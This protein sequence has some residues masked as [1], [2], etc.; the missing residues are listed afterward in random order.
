MAFSTKQT[1]KALPPSEIRQLE[2]LTKEQFA[3]LF[4]MSVRNVER[5]IEVGRIRAHRLNSRTVRIHRSQIEAYTRLVF[6]SK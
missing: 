2:W 1:V 3:I 4:A 6:A 5:L